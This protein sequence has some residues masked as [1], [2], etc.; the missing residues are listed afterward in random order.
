MITYY[1]SIGSA[2]V[3]IWTDSPVI[4]AIPT[5]VT[6]AC[7]FAPKLI[8]IGLTRK[9]ST[10]EQDKFNQFKALVH[11]VAVNLKISKPETISLRVTRLFKTNVCSVGSTSSFGGSLICLGKEFFDN[12]DST[13]AKYAAWLTLMN[14]I[15]HSPVE[16]GKYL[17][18]CSDEKRSEIFK[19]AKSSQSCLSKDEMQYLFAREL[20]HAKQHH[21]LR[22]F[23][24]M[25]LLSS[26]NKAAFVFST[27]LSIELALI[28]TLMSL[29]III[30]STIKI[31]RSHE[32][33]ADFESAAMKE[34]Q[35]GFIDFQKKALICHLSKI[36]GSTEAKVKKM[37]KSR[38]WFSMRPNPAKRLLH[39]V[40]L[41]EKPAEPVQAMSKTAWAIA[42]VGA[43][44]ILNRCFS[45]AAKILYA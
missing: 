40:H 9:F 45:N 38:D 11:E 16:L 43:S 12:Y 8:P 42:L 29:P 2:L 19:L 21:L 15:P 25:L 32:V 3:N 17:D 20:S 26:A 44:D 5:A 30:I 13:D 24:L 18:E 7:A 39:A 22:S 28:Y 1:L 41:S 27:T 6:A 33:E 36:K 31:A 10:D 4:K 35:K 37:L 14:E 23:G 34:Y